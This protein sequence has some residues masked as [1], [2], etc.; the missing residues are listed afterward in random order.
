MDKNL[1]QKIVNLTNTS[2]YPITTTGLGFLTTYEDVSGLTLQELA[3]FQAEHLN[4]NSV[5]QRTFCANAFKIMTGK[6]IGIAL[7]TKTSA[8][9]SNKK[10]EL[11]TQMMI[12]V[13]TQAAYLNKNSVE[14][15]TFCANAFKMALTGN[16]YDIV[17]DLIFD[18]SEP[19]PE[20][21]PEPESVLR[22]LDP[23]DEILNLSILT[24][25]P[26]VYEFVVL[27]DVSGGLSVVL[28]HQDYHRF[29]YTTPYVDSSGD[30]SFLYFQ[31]KTRYK[32]YK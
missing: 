22:I 25:T 26:Y 32:R 21:E 10:T 30:G 5:E 3:K 6:D 28:T 15:R 4:E 8:L 14:Q 2:I 23:S 16:S 27:T 19:E 7:E 24:T 31:T 13:A 11:F 20:P 17:L 1:I 9:N 18:S 12:P 29:E